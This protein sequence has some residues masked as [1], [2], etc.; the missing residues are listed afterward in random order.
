MFFST[1]NNKNYII[2]ISVCST[3]ARVRNYFC[4][5]TENGNGI[6]VTR[7]KFLSIKVLY[8]KL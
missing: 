7:R 6:K 3:K 8:T 4:D 2:S 5:V 1:I